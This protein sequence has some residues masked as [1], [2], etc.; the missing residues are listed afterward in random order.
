MNSRWIICMGTRSRYLTFQARLWRAEWADRSQTQQSSQD[1]ND[2][3]LLV[4]GGCSRDCPPWGPGP[5]GQNCHC[6]GHSFSQRG[7]NI[8]HTPWQHWHVMHSSTP[9][10]WCGSAWSGLRGSASWPVPRCSTW[11]LMTC[12]LRT[13]FCIS[14]ERRLT[15]HWPGSRGSGPSCPPGGGH[16]RSRRRPCLYQAVWTILWPGDQMKLFLQRVTTQNYTVISLRV[17]GVTSPFP[18]LPFPFPHSQFQSLDNWKL[19]CSVF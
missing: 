18:H 14:G 9:S 2:D 15:R 3:P 11:L 16:I 5:C 6:G 8:L 4:W 7:M 1:C 17:T 19:L 10:L 12:T 13:G